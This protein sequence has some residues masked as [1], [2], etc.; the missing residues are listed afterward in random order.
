VYKLTPAGQESVLYN[1][2]GPPDGDN[3]NGD[4]VLDS[5]GNIYGTTIGGGTGCC[6]QQ[7]GVV[8]KVDPSGNETVLY[9]FSGGADG[10][11]S[12]DGLFRDSAGNLYGTTHYGGSCGVVFEVDTA[13]VETVLYSF[14]CGA[15]GAFPN[16]AVVLDPDGNIYG[17]TTGGGAAGA[18]V[19]FKI[20]ERGR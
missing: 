20:P 11:T 6:P 13:D 18:G 7:P 14:T 10:N 1:F 5:A 12:F 15:D 8:F 16:T 2:K 9:S 4:V 3:P 19:V 17:T